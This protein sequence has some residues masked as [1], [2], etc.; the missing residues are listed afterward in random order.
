MASDPQRLAIP[1][2]PVPDGMDD[3]I[4]P[5][6]KELLSRRQA[7]DRL[8]VSHET[9][10]IRVQAGLIR[11][12]RRGREVFFHP[13][14]IAAEEQRNLERYKSRI[15]PDGRHRGAVVIPPEPKAGKEKSGGSKVTTVHMSD[16]PEY[17]GEVAAR[18]C[19]LF[20]EGKTQRE[21]VK[22]L[23]ITFELV[24]HLYV[25][26]KALGQEW[27]LSPKHLVATRERLGWAE[28]PP[29]GQGFVAALERTIRKETEKLTREATRELTQ[30]SSGSEK[31]PVEGELT[32][33]ERAA[34][35]ELESQENDE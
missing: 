4:I 17:S 27:H 13:D 22:E 35:A 25:K 21:V 1:A 10:R 15:R 3:G 7:M 9:L 18:A 5:T 30:P 23:K 11:S 19:E 32:E 33:A 29:T 20:D 31:A 14:D 2:P 12:I 28:N 16:A 6:G 34:V 8:G 26:W 24:E